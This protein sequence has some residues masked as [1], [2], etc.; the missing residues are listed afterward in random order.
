M[1]NLAPKAAIFYVLEKP[2]FSGWKAEPQVTGISAA[3]TQR[4]AEVRSSA[5]SRYFHA[6]ALGNVILAHPCSKHMANICYYKSFI[7]AWP[8]IIANLCAC[9][10]LQVLPRGADA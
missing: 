1:R 8:I 3:V 6:G 9:E 7:K 5:I 2:I 4:P 10:D